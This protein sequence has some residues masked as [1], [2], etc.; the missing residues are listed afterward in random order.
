[1]PTPRARAFGKS[2]RRRRSAR[3]RTARRTKWTHGGSQ[4]GRDRGGARRF[5]KRLASGRICRR[6]AHA[7][8]GN[9]GGCGAEAA[10][11]VKREMYACGGQRRG[12]RGGVE[13]FR[14]DW[15]QS[16]YADAARTLSGN[17]GGDVAA[18]AVAGRRRGCPWRS[19]RPGTTAG[20]LFWRLLHDQSIR[21]F[22]GIL[23]GPF[24]RVLARRAKRAVR[25]PG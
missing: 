10:A 24:G 21:T 16:K 12:D 17:Q 25:Q 9:Q 3:R 7:H 15:P 13:D 19:G 18:T 6:R 5:S 2:R 20:N 14:R 1:M 11:R 4:R 8:S 23:A 22:A